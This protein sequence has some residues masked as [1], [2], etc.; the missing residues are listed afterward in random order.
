MKLVGTLK[1]YH[2]WEE[3]ILIWRATLIITTC[4]GTDTL[5]YTTAKDSMLANKLTE[6]SKTYSFKD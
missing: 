6:W 4:F 2:V 3:G 1:I 5:I